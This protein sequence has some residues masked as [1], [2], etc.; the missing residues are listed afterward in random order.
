MHN[1]TCPLTEECYI[2]TYQMHRK[3]LSLSVKPCYILAKRKVLLALSKSC[4]SKCAFVSLFRLGTKIWPPKLNSLST[5]ALDGRVVLYFRNNFSIVGNFLRHS[6]SR[7]ASLRYM[8]TS[9]TASLASRVSVPKLKKSS[10]D[11]GWLA[12]AWLSPETSSSN[13]CCCSWT[14]RYVTIE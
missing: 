1:I 8:S 2:I 4:H 3:R 5:G 11:G 12:D 9:T 10:S 7:D 13:V 14:T 6:M